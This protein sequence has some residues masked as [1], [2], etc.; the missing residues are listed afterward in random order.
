M[1][2]QTKNLSVLQYANGYTG[3]H[4]TTTDTAEDVDSVGYFN[5]ASDMLKAG[6][7]IMLNAN[8]DGVLVGGHLLVACI[9]DG[10]VNIAVLNR[11]SKQEPDNP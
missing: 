1:S 11:A 6:D 5:D 9:D 8:I 4:Y 7:T 2:F 10:I 3:W